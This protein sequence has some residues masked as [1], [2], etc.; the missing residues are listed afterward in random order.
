MSETL[1]PSRQEL[2][3]MQ[4]RLKKLAEENTRLSDQLGQK[5]AEAA[6]TVLSAEAL[7]GATLA[8]LK[9]QFRRERAQTTKPTGV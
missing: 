1:T 7:R 6:G 3:S 2:A 5:P 8:E 9:D 4:S